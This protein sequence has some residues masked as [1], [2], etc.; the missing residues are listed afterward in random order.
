[1][2]NCISQC[3]ST[4]VVNNQGVDMGIDI[5]NINDHMTE[6]DKVKQSFDYTLFNDILSEK[7]QFLLSKQKNE[8]NKI[9]LFTMIWAVKESFTKLIGLGLTHTN[10]KSITVFNKTEFIDFDL[11]DYK[12]VSID[13]DVVDFK[14]YW[15]NNNQNVICICQRSLSSNNLNFPLKIN[16]LSLSK[17]L[18]N[19]SISLLTSPNFLQKKHIRYISHYMAYLPQQATSYDPNRLTI[20]FYTLLAMY[21]LGVENKEKNEQI[22]YLKTLYIDSKDFIGFSPHKRHFP[23]GTPGISQ[24]FFAIL[25]FLLLGV[26][27]FEFINIDKICKNLV[28]NLEKCD[29]IREFYMSCCVLFIFDRLDLIG[30]NYIIDVLENKCF[31]ENLGFINFGKGE[32]HSGYISCFASIYKL[33]KIQYGYEI[34]KDKKILIF[35]WLCH[36]QIFKN[37]E[38]EYPGNGGFNGRENKNADTCYSFWNFSAMDYFQVT[39]KTPYDLKQF[40]NY[41]F[42]MQD[43]MK[44]GFGKLLPIDNDNDEIDSD[45]FHSFTALCALAVV[46]EILDTTLCLPKEIFQKL[47]TIKSKK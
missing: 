9:R 6:E 14:L 15:I 4:M 26:E 10:L 17:L 44:G 34:S 29:D 38:Q 2:S 43:S 11:L 39:D 13:S 7:E 40:E 12:N 35:E 41:I 24:T 36:R 30:L 5:A 16:K 3:I 33:L 37:M 8:Q 46:D 19:E 27:D 23:K 18:S 28:E 47:V 20:I 21:L 31:V 25:N 45:L 32:L 22:A 42:Q 1:M